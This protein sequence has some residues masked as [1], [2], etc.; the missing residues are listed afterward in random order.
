MAWVCVLGLDYR[1]RWAC[2]RVRLQFSGCAVV[3]FVRGYSSHKMYG[4]GVCYWNR[5]IWIILGK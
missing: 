1:C 3:L 4:G 5:V 2:S